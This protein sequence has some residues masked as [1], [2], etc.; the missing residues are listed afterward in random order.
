MFKLCF[1]AI[2]C[3]INS[4]LIL[5]LPIFI[6][7][8]A[9][10]KANASTTE[11]ELTPVEQRWL[12]NNPVVAFTGDPNWL[13]YEAFNKEGEYIG[14]VAEHFKVISKVS[15]LKFKMSPSKTWTESTQK[16]KFGLVDV[17]SETDDSDLRSNLSFPKPYIENPIVIVMN[18][19]GSHV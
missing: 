4:L 1:Q 15:G 5:L 7:T 12:D 6:V 2:Y 11:L 18:G 10:V 14:I 19:N 16:A 17:L 13:P 8:F 3:S 9:T